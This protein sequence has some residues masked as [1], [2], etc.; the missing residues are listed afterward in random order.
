MSDEATRQVLLKE[1]EEAVVDDITL[2]NR[3]ID[4]PASLTDGQ[5]KRLKDAG[6]KLEVLQEGADPFDALKGR[7]LDE[8]FRASGIALEGNPTQDDK[9]EALKQA[10][11]N[12]DNSGGDA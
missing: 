5:I 3:D 12:D 7:E 9:R 8:Q 6:A 11:D 4:N 2:S 1:P 10:R